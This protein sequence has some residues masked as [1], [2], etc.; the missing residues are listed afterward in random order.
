M[1]FDFS[2]HQSPLI[3]SDTKLNRERGRDKLRKMSGPSSLDIFLSSHLNEDAAAL[4]RFFARCR[5]KEAQLSVKRIT[6]EKKVETRKINANS[7][8]SYG[9]TTTRHTD[10][11]TQTSIRT[12]GRRQKLLNH[13]LFCSDL[14]LILFC[15]QQKHR[16]RQKEANM[17]ST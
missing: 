14:V 10:N 8:V 9:N 5:L 3:R 7:L 6:A 1:G 12:E 2:R 15:S 17:S 4:I 13:F 16:L 11:T